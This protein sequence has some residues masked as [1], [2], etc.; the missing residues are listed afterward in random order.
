[1]MKSKTTQLKALLQSDETE[2]I[3]EAHNGLA[4]KIAEEAGFRGIWGSGLA[5]S[6]QHAVR[7]NNELSW[8]QVVNILEFMSDATAIPILLDGDTGYGDFNNMR[9]LVRK[10]EQRQIAG[11]CIE[12]KL[13][14]KT[15]SFIQGEQQELEDIET[16]CGKIQAGKDAQSDDD[17]CIVARVEAFI[18]GWGLEE[19][20]KRGEAY[21][22]AG[23]D[24][25]LIHSKLSKPDEILAFARE[26][27]NRCPLVIV[28]TKYYSTQTEVFRQ[29][30]ISLVIWANHMIRASISAMQNTARTIFETE[31]LVDVEGRVA[32]VQEIFRLQG[33]DELLEAEKIYARSARSDASAIILAASRG[34]GMDELTRDK[35]KVMI[36]VAGQT[37]LRRLVDKFKL[38]GINEITVVGG[39]H[40]EAIDTQGVNVVVNDQWESSDEL[41]SLRCALDSVAGDTVLLY[42]DLLFRTYILSTL[43]DWDSEL[44]VVVDSSPL[45]DAPGNKNDLAYCSAPDDRAMYQQKVSLEKVSRDSQWQGRKPDGRWIGM[46]RASGAGTPHLLEALFQLE[47]ENN[48]ENKE[49]PDLINRLVE[50]G[51]SPQVQYISGHWMDINN[52]NDLQRAGDFAHHHDA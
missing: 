41:V 45:D 40:H 12:D 22:R 4:A 33:A 52:L 39:Y 9:R 1:M 35:P 17:F 2:F 23:A 48:F 3:L 6:A 37:V 21:R 38:Q 47:S 43:L 14:P 10:L 8:T 31:S 46:L 42:G 36:P 50:N 27:D 18:A 26:W 25:I 29:H 19:A 11:V 15:N 30:K 32:P 13:F 49:L 7:D 28:P 44:L 34:R 51:H 24:A 20:L 16:F 5:L